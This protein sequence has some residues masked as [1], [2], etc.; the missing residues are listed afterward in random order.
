MTS[1]INFLIFLSVKFLD[2]LSNFVVQIV[3]PIL[4][5]LVLFKYKR[6]IMI[7]NSNLIHSDHSFVLICMLVCVDPF[8][9]LCITQG[10]GNVFPLPWVVLQ[11]VPTLS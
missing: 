2:D 3:L 10:K 6:L 5:F 7:P 4:N 9:P 11:P 1:A 8:K